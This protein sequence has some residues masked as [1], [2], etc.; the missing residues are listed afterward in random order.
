MEQLAAARRPSCLDKSRYDT[1]NTQFC[2][3]PRCDPCSQLVDQ[4]DLQMLM[5]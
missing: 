1:L 4:V 5:S 3:A 2:A